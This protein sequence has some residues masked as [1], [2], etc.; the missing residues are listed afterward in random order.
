MPA[1]IPLIAND[2]AQIAQRVEVQGVHV[3]QDDDSI[4]EVRAQMERPIIV[5]KSTHSMEQAVG[6]SARRRR[7]HWLR[8]NLL[9]A[10]ETRLLRPS[11]SR[12]FAKLTNEFPFPFF[13]LAESN[14]KISRK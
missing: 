14:W 3:G 2:H 9:H 4:E 13:A 6:R 8:S 11:G 5:G 10:H 12:K 7:L 1:E